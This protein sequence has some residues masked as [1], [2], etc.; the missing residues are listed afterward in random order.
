MAEQEIKLICPRWRNRKLKLAERFWAKVTKAGPDDCWL[1]TAAAKTNG[2]GSFN[3][4]GKT[5]LAHRVAFVLI[6]SLEPGQDVLHKCDVKLCV[7]PKHLYAGTDYDNQRDAVV[8]G[9]LASRRGALNCNAKLTQAKVEE[10]RR[11]YAETKLS[12]ERIG[13]MY[14]VSQSTVS[15]VVLHKHWAAS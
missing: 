9:R 11:I 13:Q 5:R 2:Y 4:D 3:V 15:L 12:Q 1:W 7:N 14:G 6:D 10:I 8:R